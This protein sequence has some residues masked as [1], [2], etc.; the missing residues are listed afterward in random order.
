MT[1][2]LIARMFLSK[3]WQHCSLIMLELHNY[4]L[5]KLFSDFWLY[6]SKIV[7]FVYVLILRH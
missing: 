2:K 5:T 1:L 7:F 6:F 4:L 3:F